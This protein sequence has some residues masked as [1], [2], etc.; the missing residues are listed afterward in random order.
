MDRPLSPH[1]AIYSWKISSTLSIVHRMTGVALS[2][3]ALVLV[4]WLVSIVSGY[5]M[6]SVVNDLLS[7]IIGSLALFGWT[8]CFF[9]HLCNGIRHMCWDVGKG[10]E[11]LRA[12]QSG[13]LVLAV[14][15]ILT[16]G[17]WAVVLA[18]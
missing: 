6:Y 10:F 13:M 3:G 8:F 5:N 11:R 18:G 12:Q 15:I 9:Y 17:L 2:F 4:G 1:L 16:V 7:S 14:A